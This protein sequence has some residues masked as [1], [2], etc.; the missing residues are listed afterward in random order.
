MCEPDVVLC[1]EEPGTAV[2][3]R[4]ELRPVLVRLRHGGFSAGVLSFFAANAGI[5]KS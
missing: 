1:T 4:M 3:R 2:G 5:A